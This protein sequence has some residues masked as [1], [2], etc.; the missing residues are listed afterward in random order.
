MNILK[1]IGRE[2]E[3][4][5]KD[6]STYENELSKIVSNSSFLVIGGAGSIGQAVSKEILSVLVEIAFLRKRDVM[7]LI[8]TY[9]SIFYIVK[10]YINRT[11]VQARAVYYPVVILLVFHVSKLS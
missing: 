4:F 10:L 11:Q 2:E 8:G 5:E 3:I 9:L 1:L 7:L 6:I